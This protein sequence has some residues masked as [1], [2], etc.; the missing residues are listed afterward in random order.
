MIVLNHNG[1]GPLERCLDAVEGQALEAEWEVL[2][3]DNGSTDGSQEAVRRRTGVR[4]VEAGRNLGFAAGNN[5][6]IRHAQGRYVVLLNND[7]YPRAG[8]LQALLRA[9][10]ADARVGAVTSKLLFDSRPATIQNAG[11]LLLDDGAGVDRGSGQPDDGRFAQREEVFGFCG[12]GAL[13][14]R[15]ALDDVGGFD[16]RF[17][18]YYE[19]LDLSWRL[20]LRGWSVLFE[21]AAV[22]DHGH[23]TSSR[24]WSAFFTF[25][26]DRNRVFTLLKNARL[27]FLLRSLLRLGRRGAGSAPARASQHRPGGVHIPVLASLVW[28]LP[29]MLATRLQVRARKTVPDAEIERSLYPRERWQSSG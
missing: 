10:E 19:D 11:V 13:L 21:P 14:R 27:G 15:Q 22:A 17:F 18:M 12:A 24:E 23:A 20:R 2:V 6:G 25:H 29:G 7:A 28:H 4:L 9:A 3:V 16:E 8:F 26:V 1:A 5:L